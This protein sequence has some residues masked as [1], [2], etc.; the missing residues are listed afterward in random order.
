MDWHKRRAAKGVS[1]RIIYDEESREYGK[2]REK[3]K[4]TQVRYLPKDLKTPALIEIFDDYV[5]TALV[6]PKPVVFLLKSGEAAKSYLQY[7]N[8]LWKQSRP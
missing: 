8:L 1:L 6:T 5:A 4:L 2:K 7:F 3:I